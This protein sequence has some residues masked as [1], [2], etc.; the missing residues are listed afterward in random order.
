[1]PLLLCMVPCFHY[2]IRKVYD[3]TYETHWCYCHSWGLWQIKVQIW[4]QSMKV[5]CRTLSTG[6]SRYLTQ[7]KG[8]DFKTRDSFSAPLISWAQVVH[9]DLYRWY[10]INNC[11]MFKLRGIKIMDKIGYYRL[12]AKLIDHLVCQL[13]VCITEKRVI[14]TC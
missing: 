7:V 10:T 9:L 14:E 11:L 4:L 8:L 6:S 3:A 1:M 12:V 2:E 13:E 5:A